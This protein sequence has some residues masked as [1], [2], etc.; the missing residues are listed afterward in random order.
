MN[1]GRGV[2][3][4]SGDTA[5]LTFERRIAA[6]VDRVWWVLTTG[7]ALA[8]WLAP[9][10]IDLV[11]GGAVSIDFGDDGV[12]TGRITELQPPT[13]LAYTWLLEG[14][15]ESAVHWSLQAAGD[16]TV[17]RLVHRTLPAAMAD[18]YGAGWHAHVDRLQA[19]AT[20]DEVPNW[21]DRF[22]AL[23]P[24]YRS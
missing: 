3:E 19:V 20:G 12:V 24:D 2:V 8:R 11:P 22:A 6:P 23:L 16:A 21:D 9:T 18:G 14:E 4:R 1:E 10:A 13:V 7:D 5:I 15:I 17:L